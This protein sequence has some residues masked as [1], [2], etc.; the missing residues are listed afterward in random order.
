MRLGQQVCEILPLLSDPEVRVSIV[1]LKEK[2]Y[3]KSM[4]LA[5]SLE[6]PETRAGADTR[7]EFQKAE[8][9]SYAIREPDNLDERIYM[10]GDELANELDAHE[11]NYLF[12][13]Y[14]EMVNQTSPSA[15]GIAPEEFEA[16]KKALVKI[17]WSELSGQQWYTAKRFLLSIYPTLLRDNSLGFSFTNP[18]TTTNGASESIPSVSPN[19]TELSAKSAVSQ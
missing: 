5:A 4:A 14:L 13:H 11:L 9:L 15:D 16:L 19:S 12:D 3:Q 18:L 17:N 6:F 10:S 2:E 8:I 7:D 1:P